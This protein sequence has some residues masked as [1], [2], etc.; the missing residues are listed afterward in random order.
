MIETHKLTPRAKADLAMQASEA[1]HKT[2]FIKKINELYQT[3][4]SA[5]EAIESL[6]VSIERNE[7][8]ISSIKGEIAELISK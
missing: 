6:Q 5:T 3:L 2:K 8:T 4:D 7:Q 1:F